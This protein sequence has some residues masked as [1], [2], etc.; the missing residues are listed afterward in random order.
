M[1][2]PITAYG[3]TVLRKECEELEE[4]ADL[5]KLINDMFETMYDARGVGLAAPQVSKSLR[6]FVI[7]AAAFAEDDPES[8]EEKMEQEFLKTF[9]RTFINPIIEEETG[10]E[11]P[12]SEGCLSIPGIREEVF[13]KRDIIISYFDEKW[14]LKE[15]KLTGLAARVVQHEYDHIE[16]VLFT[17][18]LS[19][20]KRRLLKSRLTDISKG[21]VDVSYKMRFPKKKR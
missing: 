1:I 2:L 10:P 15:E 5:S 16:G 21:Q 6:L 7:D 8:E 14:Q 11:W 18:Y 17:D 19:P 3:D 9:Q 20:L 4:G 13:R 12:F